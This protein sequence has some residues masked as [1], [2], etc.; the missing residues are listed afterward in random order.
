MSGSG[1][2]LGEED[3]TREIPENGAKQMDKVVPTIRIE[4][5][6]LDPENPED[7]EVIPRDKPRVP[8]TGKHEKSKTIPR[9]SVCMLDVGRSN[10]NRSIANK[11]RLFHAAK[12]FCN[13]KQLF[14]EGFLH[15]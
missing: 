9:R 4:S 7:N 10:N 15:C 3:D 14:K 2:D 1:D 12:Y 5:M 13:T 8:D 11:S 6:T